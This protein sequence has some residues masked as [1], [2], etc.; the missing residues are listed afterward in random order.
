[1][2]TIKAWSYDATRDKTYYKRLPDLEQT[3]E[4]MGVDTLFSL[5]RGAVLTGKTRYRIV[6]AILSFPDGSVFPVV[7]IIAGKLGVYTAI[8][9][10]GDVEEDDGNKIR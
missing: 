1:M 2:V 7:T 10:S 4:G 3:L 8:N 5:I 6:D 9:A